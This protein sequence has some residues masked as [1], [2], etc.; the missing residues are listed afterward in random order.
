[1]RAWLVAGMVAVLVGASAGICQDPLSEANEAYRQGD[2]QKAAELFRQAAEA[3]T[4]PTARA[5]IRVKLA[6][7]L[8]ALKN[9]SKAEEALASALDDEPTLELVPDYYTDDFLALF[10]RVKTRVTAPPPPSA[11]SPSPLTR[12]APASAANALRQK[13]AQ[14]IDPAAIDSV[15]AETQQLEAASPPSAQP[16][17][18][19]L[20]AEILDRLGRTE[21]ALESRGRA[22]AMRAAAQVMPGGSA[23]PL[24]TMLEGRRLVADGQPLDAA[25]LMRGVLSAQPAC[26]PALEVLGEAY[27]A[28]GRLN[29][30]YDVLRTT[31]LESEKPDVL[32]QLGEIDLRRGRLAPAKDSFRR[33]VEKDPANDRGLAA[34]GLLAAR[35]EDTAVARETLDRALQTNGTLFEARVVRAQLALLDNDPSAAVG[36]LRRALQVRP[37][38]PWAAAWLGVAF[39]TSG[40]AA[41]AEE[42]LKSA[43]KD[44]NSIFALALVEALRRQGKLEEALAV[45]LDRSNPQ[46]AILLALC[47]LDRSDPVQ[48]E[49]LLLP[50]VEKDA[51]DGSARYLLGLAYHAQRRW[52]DSSRTLAS[53][54]ALPRAPSLARDAASIAQATAEAQALQDA[55][56]TPPLPAKQD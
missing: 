37:D 43:P 31:L 9:R 22:A 34:L 36:H 38:D 11:G 17:I 40:D 52:Q 48:A 2:F 5:E 39:L 4:R 35:M 28:A 21:E 54:A 33:V 55:A 49:T 3:E 50:V 14:A 29:D 23:V 24:D 27:L 8:F 30:A 26:A 13:L 6:W 44:P 10:S 20:R 56:L 15:L 1:M 12:T 51:Q 32:L 25:A 47:H 45:Q 42:K 53:A 41:A 19:Q 7:T 16:E 46:S 18:L